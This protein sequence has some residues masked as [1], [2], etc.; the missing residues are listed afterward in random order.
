MIRPQDWC[1]RWLAVATRHGKARAL[2]AP[3]RR[4]LGVRLCT[5]RDLDTDALGTFTGEIARTQPP[6][7]T[8]A[9]KARLALTTAP[10]ALAVLA[11]EA[12]FGPDPV[13]GYVPLHQEWLVCVPASAP[14]VVIAVGLATHTAQFAHRPLA[15]DETPSED[16]LHAA[17]F[18]AHALILRA[19]TDPPRF[20]K[21]L[22]SRAA[23]DA[24][25]AQARNCAVPLRL[26]TD[27][28][29][30][31]NPTRMVQ[32]ARLG[33][34]MA[35]RLASACPRC[36]GAGFGL[37]ELLLGLPCAVCDAPTAQVGSERHTCPWCAHTVIHTRT[38]QADPAHCPI[39]NP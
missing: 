4:V 31:L 5:P 21:A 38:G 11:S 24:A 2:R 35:Q 15:E 28:R 13:L 23:L 17:G 10:G 22:R 20:W 14:Q 32:L 18:P 6:L 36:G 7:R 8:A 26:E 34:R 3:L 37:E 25:L 1:G 30:H 29:A 39:C 16:F 19:Q 12:S 33:V 9:A 27:M